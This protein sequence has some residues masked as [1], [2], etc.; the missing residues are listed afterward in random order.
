MSYVHLLQNFFKIAAE[1]LCDRRARLV[2][3]LAGDGF[4]RDPGGHIGNNG[5]A[6]QRQAA[7]RRCQRLRHS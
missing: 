6:Q 7:V 5:N 2:D 4:A 1:P 3:L